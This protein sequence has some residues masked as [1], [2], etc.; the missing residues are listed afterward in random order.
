LECLCRIIGRRQLNF[1][2]KN[3]DNVVPNHFRKIPEAIT[4]GIGSTAR[5]TELKL[6]G[7]MPT[8]T[9]RTIVFANSGFSLHT[10][11]DLIVKSAG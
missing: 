8:P 11:S 6:D 3:L 5:Y 4:K 7:L 1:P 2:A 10:P 9:H